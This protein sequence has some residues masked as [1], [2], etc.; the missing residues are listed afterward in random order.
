[1]T[2][3]IKTI[4]EDLDEL[5][6]YTMTEEPQLHKRLLEMWPWIKD[7]KDGLITSRYHVLNLLEEIIKDS[8]Y[9]LNYKALTQQEQS[10][11]V[12]I[13]TPSRRYW[14][15]VLFPCRAESF[16]INSIV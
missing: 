9:W 4:R 5:L 7:K 14:S 2:T 3:R 11:A 15:L 12:Q 6:E 8:I 16:G 13:L 10:Q 1:M